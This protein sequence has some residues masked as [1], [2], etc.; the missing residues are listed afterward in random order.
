MHQHSNR[1][2]YR[3]P[4]SSRWSKIVLLMMQN[5]IQYSSTFTSTSTSLKGN[6]IVFMKNYKFRKASVL[7]SGENR[8]KCAKKNCRAAF[9]TKGTEN[10]ITRERKTHNHS[11]KNFQS[12]LI[13]GS[14]RK[15]EEEDFGQQSK[16]V[17]VTEES[18]GNFIR[19][20]T[21]QCVYNTMGNAIPMPSPD[22]ECFNSSVEMTMEVIPLPPPSVILDLN[23]STFLTFI[24]H[25]MFLI[26]Y[27]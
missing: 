19:T 5:E 25:Y 20:T 2:V 13:G 10:V 22:A 17:K 1:L 23:V 4:A 26:P 8:W 15:T 18:D 14:K 6:E 3:W 9:Y 27:Q 16:F 11:C 12:I 24:I 21:E 7:A